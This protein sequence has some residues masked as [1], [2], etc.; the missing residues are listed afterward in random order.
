MIKYF[1]KR[2]VIFLTSNRKKED[3]RERERKRL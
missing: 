1:R 2:N 3:P